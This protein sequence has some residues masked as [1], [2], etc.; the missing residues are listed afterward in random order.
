M[1]Q[2]VDNFMKDAFRENHEEDLNLSNLS[3]M[4]KFTLES[5]AMTDMGKLPFM[6]PKR[7]KMS[8]PSINTGTYVYKGSSF[9]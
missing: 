2:I 5:V 1:R 7:K 4:Q 9:H 6:M 8:N 3:S